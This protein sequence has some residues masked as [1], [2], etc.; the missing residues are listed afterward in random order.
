[1][2]RGAE[3][4]FPEFQG[5]AD[6]GEKEERRRRFD[7][8]SVIGSIAPSGCK[9]VLVVFSAH[10]PAL[11]AP[12]FSLLQSYVVRFKAYGPREGEEKL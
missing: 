11:V 4:C 8:G 10:D 7:G 5:F 12:L 3:V 9:H 6:E 2:G 1:M